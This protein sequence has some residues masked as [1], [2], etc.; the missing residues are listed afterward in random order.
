MNTEDVGGR[1]ME[2][3]VNIVLWIS[4]NLIVQRRGKQIIV[5]GARV[6]VNFTDKMFGRWGEILLH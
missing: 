4:E 3:A 5:E 6:K 1:A 2:G